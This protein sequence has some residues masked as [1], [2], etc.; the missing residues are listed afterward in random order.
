[1]AMILA[2]AL[3]SGC[4]HVDSKG[5]R[6]PRSQSAFEE[7]ARELVNPGDDVEQAKARMK[8]AGFRISDG[9][10]PGVWRHGKNAI[11]AAHVTHSGPRYA[12]W[13]IVVKYNEGRVTEVNPVFDK[14]WALDF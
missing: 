11:S 13:I 9:S 14:G 3:L 8:A 12:Q 6:F 2:V 10:G 7:R 4:V 1:M 5:N